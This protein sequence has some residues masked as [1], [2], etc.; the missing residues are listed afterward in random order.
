MSRRRILIVDDD[1]SVRG[2]L[3]KALKQRGDAVL[4]ATTGEE[5]CEL[6]TSHSVDAVLMD[7][8][9]PT[10]SGQ[11]LFYIILSQWPALV[12]RL[13]VTSSN[14]DSE[15]QHEWLMLYSLPVIRKPFELVEVFQ[16]LD[17]LTSSK[18]RRANGH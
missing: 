16:M 8:H 6:L 14:P 17:S 7:L 12:P 18:R 11:T 13:A 15:D 3:E 1:P 9:M 4:I 10:M 5:A 2:A